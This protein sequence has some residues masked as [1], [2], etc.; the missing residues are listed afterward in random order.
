[1]WRARQ[2]AILARSERSS[3]R[4]A[5]KTGLANFRAR[6]GFSML[7]RLVLN[8]RPQVT[9]LPRPPKVLGLQAPL[10]T[11]DIHWAWLRT[12]THGP[13]CLSRSKGHLTSDSDLTVS[14]ANLDSTA[15]S[16]T[17]LSPQSSASAPLSYHD[18]FPLLYGLASALLSSLPTLFQS[19]GEF[20][21]CCPGWSTLAQSRL[22][23][24]S[25]SRVQCGTFLLTH[26]VITLSS[27][28]SPASWIADTTGKHHHTQL[29]FVFL[30]EGDIDFLVTVTHIFETT[31]LSRLECSGMSSAHC[32]HCPP[33]RFKR[34]SCLSLP[35][36]G[37]HCAVIQAGLNSCAQAI[38]LA[39][40][41]QSTGITSVS[42]YAWPKTGVPWCDLGSLQPSPPGFKRFSCF[43]LLS[44]WDYRH[45][46]PCPAN[47]CIFSRDGVS[48]SW[49]GW[50]QT[51]DLVIYLPWP[52]KSLTLLPQLGSS[53]TIS[54]HCNLRLPGSSDSLASASPVSFPLPRLECSGMISAHCSLKLM[55]SGHSPTSASQ[56][57]GTTGMRH[58]AWLIFVSFVQTGFHHVAH[59][60]LELLG[61]S[62]LL[63]LV[64]Q[65]TQFLLI[66]QAELGL[67]TSGDPPALPS[68]CWDTV[69]LRGG[70]PSP[71]NWAFP[72]SAVLALSSALPIAVL[73]VGMGPVEPLGTQSRTLHT[74]KRRA[75]QKS[76]AGDPRSHSVTQAG[77]Q[78]HNLSSLQPPSPGFKRFSCLSLPSSWY[79]RH[80]PPHLA[81]FSVFLVETGFHHVGQA[82]LELLT[83]ND[84]P[85]LTS[86]KTGF[87]HVVQAGPEH[88]DSSDLP[89]SPSQS[90]GITGA[91]MQWR[92]FSSLQ[93]LPSSLKRFFCL[94]LP[95]SWDYRRPPPRP[96]NFVFL[97]K[98]G[99][100]HVGQAGLKLLTSM[101]WSRYIT[102][103]GLK[104]LASSDLP[105]SDSQSVGIT[106]S[107]TLSPRLECSGTILAHCNLCLQGSSNSPALA[108]QVAGITDGVLL[109][110]PRLECNGAILAHC[111]LR[112]LETG[113][114]HVGQAGLKLPTSGDLPTSA[115][116]SAEIT[117]INPQRHFVHYAALYLLLWR[118][119]LLLLLLL[120]T[121]LVGFLFGTTLK[122]L[123]GK[124]LG[125]RSISQIGP[126]IIMDLIRRFYLFQE[127][128]KC[129]NCKTGGEK[130][131]TESHF[132]RSGWS[133]AAQSQL[134][135]TS[136]PKFKPC[137][138]NIFVLLVETGFHYIGQAGFQLLASSDPPASASQSAGI[139]GESHCARP[140]NYFL[141]IKKAF[142]DSTRSSV[143]LLPGKTESH[144]VIQAGVQWCDLSLLQPPPPGFN[145]DEASPCWSGWSRMPDLMICLPW[146]P[147]AGPEFLNSSN[148]PVSL[149]QS[150]GITGMSHCTHPFPIC[151]NNICW[152]YMQLQHLPRDNSQAYLHLRQLLLLLLLLQPPESLLLLLPLA[153]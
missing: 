150:A 72:G 14:N 80:M 22:T 84:P 103:A 137:L 32:N 63:N 57:A 36:M 50:F 94:S 88:L 107:L 27:R 45:P 16:L 118:W 60:G 21:S 39:L 112:L 119:L 48:P 116:Q 120:L 49:P 127:R 24:T 79:Y 56:V 42:H 104:L 74:E 117:G 31:L 33:P 98:T 148:P 7:V 124:L 29:I 99:F 76:L 38:P 114:L 143:D 58:H 6:R 123:L 81:Q 85:A 59:A 110:L 68:Q 83:S 131:R 5:R 82:G 78:W 95:S 28:D 96:A 75:G 108:S 140:Q 134:I 34:F 101:I 147:K 128:N 97:V 91:G 65:K 43:N 130:T 71:Q 141:K 73:L 138:A 67:L 86:Q 1:M 35:K 109:L 145:R 139:T 51:P 10:R 102:P 20:H 26:L 19:T 13:L 17:H 151:P 142:G 23:A 100:H 87:Q 25:A 121:L 144:S 146:P 136:P 153:Y 61:S 70:V 115:S 37:S 149:S 126:D 54:A 92:N 46:P 2:E 105:T 69:F 64:S 66:G 152:Q 8:S 3:R 106:G 132:F 11:H 15:S 77:G 129:G 55:G 89:T 62:D 122:E 12:W 135:A 111:N 47:S 133:A 30:V 9:R 40:A 41:C 93:P 90:A 4:D 113:L 18:G 52:P 53:G 44:S 125:L